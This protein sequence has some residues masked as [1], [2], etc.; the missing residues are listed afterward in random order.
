MNNRL[1]NTQRHS[2]LPALNRP[3]LRI[4]AAR[5]S[6]GL[7]EPGQDSR[8]LQ[9]RLRHVRSSKPSWLLSLSNVRGFEQIHGRSETHRTLSR[10]GGPRAGSLAHGP[11]S[12]FARHL[13]VLAVVLVRVL[14]RCHAVDCRR[15]LKLDAFLRDACSRRRVLLENALG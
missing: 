6:L 12:L 10:L 5:V 3:G 11:S 15:A 14:N 13:G 1:F 7:I 8:S 9:S 2:L 4:H